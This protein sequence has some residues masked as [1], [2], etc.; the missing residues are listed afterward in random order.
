M[1]YVEIV[2]P[3]GIVYQSEAESVNV[4]TSMGMIGI[5]PGHR[6]ILAK[7]VAGE[8]KVVQNGQSISLAVDEGF[9]E[10]ANDRVAFAVEGAIDVQEIDLESIHQAEQRARDAIEAAK[11]DPNFDREDLHELES[12]LKFTMFQE[13]IKKGRR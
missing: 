4:P 10:V 6:P 3:D 5:Y 2:T 13:L 7:V 1:L 9:V 8:L 12:Q 11:K